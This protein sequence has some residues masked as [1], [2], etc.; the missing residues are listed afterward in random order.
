MANKT[1]KKGMTIDVQPLRNAEEISALRDALKVA[2]KKSGN[3][4]RNLL[5]FNIR[6]NTGLRIGDIVKLQIAD[7][8]GRSSFVIKEGKT[9]KART[10]HLSAIMADIADYLA[11]SYLRPVFYFHREK[12][13]AALLLPRHTEL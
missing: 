7:V 10:V 8:S 11:E 5:L 12:E 1:D 6:I 2:G 9:Q 3:A 4:A 13:A